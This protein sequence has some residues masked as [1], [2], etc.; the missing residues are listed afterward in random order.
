MPAMKA[1][2]SPSSDQVMFTVVL[3]LLA[4][5]GIVLWFRDPSNWHSGPSRIPWP[6]PAPAKP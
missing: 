4:L 6:E 1:R 3:L 5:L 2:R